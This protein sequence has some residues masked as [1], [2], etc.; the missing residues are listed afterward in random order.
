[1][2]VKLYAVGSYSDLELSFKKVELINCDNILE[3]L[4][5][6]TNGEVVSAV[7]DKPVMIEP[8]NFGEM[9]DLRKRCSIKNKIYAFGSNVKKIDGIDLQNKI[10]K[11]VQRDGEIQLLK[12]EK[13]NELYEVVDKYRD[14]YKPKDTPK[15]WTRV[16][17]NVYFKSPWGEYIFAPIDSMMC[18]EN[19][20]TREFVVVTNTTYHSLF[21]EQG[22]KKKLD[23]IVNI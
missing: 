10:L 6:F 11:V 7:M 23:E 21:V 20:A 17:K 5:S 9:V 18:V 22:D 12:N 2:N 4:K 8:V 3:K 1:M 14:L 15:M 19:F 16:T 13:L